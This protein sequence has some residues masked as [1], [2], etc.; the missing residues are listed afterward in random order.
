MAGSTDVD[1]DEEPA[2]E[3]DGARWER[4]TIDEIFD[5]HVR[6]L[7]CEA[8]GAAAAVGESLMRADQTRRGEGSERA[9]PDEG[10]DA[11]AAAMDLEVGPTVESWTEE[12]A[13]VVPEADLTR[14]LGRR[15]AGG[16]LPGHRALREGDVFWVRVPEPARTARSLAPEDAVQARADSHVVFD[17]T[18]AA[19][20]AVKDIY[21]RVEKSGG[22]E[23]VGRA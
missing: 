6:L 2:V 22:G 9:E 3:E 17:L 15:K 5:G 18:A 12:T 23:P 1:R 19:R 7:R 10:A 8:R 21:H 13:S 20:Q 14:L 4:W 11:I 16:G